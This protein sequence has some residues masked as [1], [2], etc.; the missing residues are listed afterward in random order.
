MTYGY[1]EP[2]A[3]PI[4]DLLDDNMMQQYVAGAREQ[5]NKSEQKMD[6]FMKSYRDFYSP[7]SDDN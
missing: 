3:M 6:D 2:V 1:D 4:I 7:I 5:Y